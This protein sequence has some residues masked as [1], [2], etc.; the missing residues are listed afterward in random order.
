M[1]SKVGMSVIDGPGSIVGSGLNASRVVDASAPAFEEDDEEAYV[2][3][4]VGTIGEG[5]SNVR[6]GGG[7]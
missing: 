1:R 2:E 6:P 5:G 4:L 3:M 7:R